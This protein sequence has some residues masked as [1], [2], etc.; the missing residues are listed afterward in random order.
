MDQNKMIARSPSNM[1][2]GLIASAL[3]MTLTNI[4]IAH[5]SVTDNDLMY[6]SIVES[7]MSTEEKEKYYIKA[8]DNYFIGSYDN[9]EEPYERIRL[10]RKE[11]NVF[12]E[13]DEVP[14]LPR[15]N[16]KVIEPKFNSDELERRIHHIEALLDALIKKMPPQNLK[17]ARSRELALPNKNGHFINIPFA[18]KEYL[19]NIQPNYLMP[20]VSYVSRI[21]YSTNYDIADFDY[22]GSSNQQIEKE[23]EII[24][25]HIK[26][27]G[28]LRKLPGAY[29]PKSLLREHANQ[30]GLTQLIKN[31]ELDFK[32]HLNHDELAVEFFG[33]YDAWISSFY[34]FLNK[35]I[36]LDVG[37]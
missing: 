8:M 33:T 13:I 30:S 28:L 10:P 16:R 34:E 29:Y 20:K 7:R 32:K 4:G 31:R 2:K 22:N 35:K 15:F 23:Y 27:A 18:N 25:L 17:E 11:L 36:K 24:Y 9:S 3:V 26:A 19:D 12:Y 1:K 6:D 21:L 37:G 5:E 14:I